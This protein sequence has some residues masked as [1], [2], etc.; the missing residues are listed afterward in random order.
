MQKQ[1]K[2]HHSVSELGNIQVRQVTEYVED[3]RT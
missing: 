3:R 1:T 2:F